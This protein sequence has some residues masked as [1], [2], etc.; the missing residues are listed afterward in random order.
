M[1]HPGADNRELSRSF[2][3]GYHWE[4]ELEALTSPRLKDE[5]EQRAIQLISFR[6]L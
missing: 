2:A 5:M 1:T 6:E 3:W 4:E